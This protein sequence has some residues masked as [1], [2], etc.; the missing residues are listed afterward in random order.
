MYHNA[1]HGAADEDGNRICHKNILFSRQY[2]FKYQK[3]INFYL[4]LN[5]AS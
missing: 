2:K 3:Y 4:I 5:L 1:N